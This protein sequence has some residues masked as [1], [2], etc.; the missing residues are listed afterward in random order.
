MITA[1]AASATDL[2]LAASGSDDDGGW[3]PYLFLL[4]GVG[5]YT[6]MF[7]RYRNVHQ[8]HKHESETRATMHD[9]RAQDHFV[10]SLRGVSN[11]RMSGAN[12]TSVRGARRSFL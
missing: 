9:V 6:L 10:R 7:I 8:R 5:F 3:F 4:S 11:S 12:H 1:L 2:V